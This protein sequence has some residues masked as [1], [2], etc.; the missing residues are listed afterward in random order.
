MVRAGRHARRSA[1]N[2]DGQVT[3][4]ALDSGFYH[5]SRFVQAYA[6]AFG[7]RPS[8]TLARRRA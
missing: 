1:A 7:E 4:I 3:M 8:E 2:G 5:L 6:R